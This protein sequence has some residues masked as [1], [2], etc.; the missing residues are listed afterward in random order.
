VRRSAPA[1]LVAPLVVGTF[2]LASAHE[3]DTDRLWLR[4]DVAR[5]ELRGQLTLNPHY[6]REDPE[7]GSASAPPATAA[8]DLLA[9][10]DR[11]LVLAIDGRRCQPQY[12]IRELWM[13]GAPSSGDIVTLRCAL[14]PGAEHF[15]VKV[16]LPIDPLIVAVQGGGGVDQQLLVRAG[17]PSPELSLGRSEA[18]APAALG[19]A[20]R[21]LVL[22]VEHIVP[23][24]LD[25]VLFV[26][27]LV[28]GARAR[29][30]P[31]LFQL[32][33]FTVAHTV[34][35]ALGSVGWVNLPARVVEP[36]IALSIAIV[37]LDSF[38]SFRADGVGHA[39]SWVV[40]GFGLLHGLG[41]ASAL[42]ETGVGSAFAVS[43]LSFNL[44]VELG[45]L[46]VV[47]AAAALLALLRRTKNLEE[48]AVRASL[49][50]IAAVAV[51]WTIRAALA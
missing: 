23:R 29:L 43:L 24:G 4:P 2:A 30:R 32:S 3:P 27:S 36:L 22:G 14:P 37:A 5:T 31:L 28:L 1:L 38:R 20:W 17:S 41:F 8:G 40:F 18:A 15:S 26:V 16:T 6:T 34:T 49:L 45:Q 39:R 42:S 44:G 25:H 46:I 51:W 7:P 50:A 10:L 21:Y 19:H 12:G 33:A 48:P 13:P 35:L 47:I 9:L 11:A